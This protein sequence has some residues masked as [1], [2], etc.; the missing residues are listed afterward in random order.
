MGWVDRS[1]LTFDS[2]P[3]GGLGLQSFD[4]VSLTVHTHTHTQFIPPG[5]LNPKGQL[6][7]STNTILKMDL[8]LP[9][10]VRPPVLA[11]VLTSSVL[12]SADPRGLVIT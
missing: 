9:K 6:Y 8:G 12:L 4:R 3:S 2:T 7:A 11:Y 5:G 1:I 10:P